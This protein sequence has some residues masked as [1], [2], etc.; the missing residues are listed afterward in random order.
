MQRPRSTLTALD[1]IAAGVAW[2]LTTV[3]VLFA[4]VYAPSFRGMF[5]DFGGELPWL[6]KLALTPWPA[7]A[8]SVVAAGA[9]V[10][11]VALGRVAAGGRRALIVA[12]FF[13][14]LGGLGVCVAG[15]YLPIVEIAGAVAP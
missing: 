8:A 4:V 15:V 14:A 2:L 9:V 1:W 5:A 6:T 13:I 12:G 3:L 7:L 11:G 10:G